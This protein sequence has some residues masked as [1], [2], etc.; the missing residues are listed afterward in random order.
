MLQRRYSDEQ[1]RA[2]EV[3]F[4]NNSQQQELAITRNGR[5]LAGV[6]SV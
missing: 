1:Q 4:M 5:V 6:G 2:P 3:T